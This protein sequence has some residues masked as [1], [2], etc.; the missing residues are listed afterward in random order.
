MLLAFAFTL[1]IFLYSFC[2]CLYRSN[3]NCFQTGSSFSWK[4]NSKTKNQ[5]GIIKNGKIY[6]YEQIFTSIPAELLAQFFHEGCRVLNEEKIVYINTDLND[7]VFFCLGRFAQ[8][9][10]IRGEAYSRVQC[11]CSKIGDGSLSDS[12]IG[13]C[14]LKSAYHSYR[15]QPYLSTGVNVETLRPNVSTSLRLKC[16]KTD[17]IEIHESV[18]AETRIL[19]EEVCNTFCSKQSF[20]LSFHQKLGDLSN[21]SCS[22][23]FRNIFR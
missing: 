19:S 2:F 20:V 8:K 9:I 6:N 21:C 5:S 16:A 13:D 15:I 11:V 7:C 22:T 12:E 14:S 1:A 10:L 23:T 3:V 17:D 18:K 4:S